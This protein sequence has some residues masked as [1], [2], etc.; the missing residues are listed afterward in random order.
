MDLT[1]IV[2]ELKEMI[3]PYLVCICDD[4]VTSRFIEERLM[5]ICDNC[6]GLMSL[7][8]IEDNESEV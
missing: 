7:R 1:N 8:R 6:G 4:F 3:K 2:D 5:Y